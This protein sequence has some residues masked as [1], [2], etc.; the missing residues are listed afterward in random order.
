MRAEAPVDEVASVAVVEP[1]VL[2]DDVLRPPEEHEAVR[3]LDRTIPAVREDAAA[4][5]HVARRPGGHRR[6]EV[7]ALSGDGEAVQVDVLGVVDLHDRV[8]RARRDPHPGERNALRAVEQHPLD[9]HARP[10]DDA[11]RAIGTRAYTKRAVES[12][13]QPDRAARVREPGDCGLE[14]SVIPDTERLARCRVGRWRR[15]QH[16]EGEHR[17]CH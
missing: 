16:H 13:E 1:V 6:R 8:L 10:P 14:L 7:G 5:P 9:P 4:D 15:R 2:D 3:P 17:G 11:Q 12:R